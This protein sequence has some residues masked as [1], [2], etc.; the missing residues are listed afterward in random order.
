MVLDEAQVGK[1]QLPRGL[2]RTVE[3]EGGEGGGGGGDV[4]EGPQELR[5]DGADAPDVLH[6]ET[7]D[8][9]QLPVR[10]VLVDGEGDAEVRAPLAHLEPPEMEVVPWGDVRRK[11]EEEWTG[12]R[13]YRLYTR[14]RMI[15]FSATIIVPPSPPPSQMHMHS[16]CANHNEL[17][18][19]LPYPTL[20]LSLHS[21]HPYV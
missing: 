21:Y 11:K 19:P 20:R 16:Q 4:V 10:V 6:A 3:N 14:D 15:D 5:V 18:Y 2:G 17:P 1:A 7:S 8:E 9:G 13:M 12:V